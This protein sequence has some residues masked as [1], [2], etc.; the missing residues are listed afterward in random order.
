[1]HHPRSR[2]IPSLG[3][4]YSYSVYALPSPIS[5]SI[6]H[7]G[8]PLLNAYSISR[9]HL[10]S[11]FPYSP[12][13]LHVSILVL[14]MRFPQVLSPTPLS[15]ILVIVISVSS[16]PRSAF[17]ISMHRPHCSTTTPHVSHHMSSLASRVPNTPTSVFLQLIIMHIFPSSQHV[18]RFITSIITHRLRTEPYLPVHSYLVQ[19]AV[20]LSV[21][22]F[23]AFCNAMHSSH[24]S[25][26]K[27]K[28]GLIL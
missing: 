17:L 9:L 27:R 6:P 4:S 16:H 3:S 10:P 18:S 8:Y 11:I 14:S 23:M 20:T 15:P 24:G 19:I 2:L 5:I 26:R 7:S 28:H 1:M 22:L 13:P 25:Q 21:A 12:S